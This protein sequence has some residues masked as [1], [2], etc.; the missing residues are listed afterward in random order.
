M[1]GRYGGVAYF[2]GNPRRSIGEITARRIA[3]RPL[4]I[5]SRAGLHHPQC[6]QGQG[7]LR[8]LQNFAELT[9]VHGRAIMEALLESLVAMGFPRAKAESAISATEGA[10][11][12]S[13]G[14]TL[15]DRPKP[16][17]IHSPS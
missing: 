1:M 3:D 5:C 6:R 11:V 13:V 15:T 8:E 12:L 17:C 16:R 14:W 2:G 9:R 10:G 7:N 4:T